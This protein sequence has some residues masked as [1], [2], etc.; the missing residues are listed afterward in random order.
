MEEAEY[1]E[2]AQ[3]IL[4]VAKDMAEDESPAWVRAA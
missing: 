1:I 4:Q 2:F 3:E